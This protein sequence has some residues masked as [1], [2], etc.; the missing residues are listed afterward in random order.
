MEDGND[1]LSFIRRVVYS[2]VRP[3]ARVAAKAGLPL[4]DFTQLAQLSL[5]EVKRTQGL[6]HREIAE[7][8]DVSSRTIDR[9]LKDLR[10][11]FFEPEVEHELP[12]KIEFMLWAEPAGIARIAQVLSKHEP[13]DIE[14]ALALLIK[15]GRVETVP[16]R[17]LKYAPTHRAN[18]LMDTDLASRIDGLNN[19][20]SVLT[21]ATQTRFIAD[22]R[23]ASARS[24][25]MRVRRQ[26]LEEFEKIYEEAVW[27]RLVALDEKATDAEDVVDMGLTF[28]WTPFEETE[29]E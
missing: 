8:L 16:G 5:Y 17:T 28:V 23:R 27:P 22:D 11:G 25:S 19:V 1:S 15:E 14:H 12:R 26:D 29:D 20:L 21:A 13:D 10:E 4:K 2:L 18:R 9:L 7:E 6:S 24:V 3:A